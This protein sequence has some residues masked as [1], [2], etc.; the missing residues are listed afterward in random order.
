MCE[1][2]RGRERKCVCVC[3]CVI[4]KFIYNS[5]VV[6]QLLVLMYVIS[7]MRL[8][9]YR[10]TDNILVCIFYNVYFH[11][12]SLPPPSLPPLYLPFLSLPP[13]LFPALP[14]PSPSPLSLF[15]EWSDFF[16]EVD[17]DVVTG[18]NIVN[19]DLPYLL[20]RASTKKVTSSPIK[21]MS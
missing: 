16:Q 11:A 10:C 1:R 19:F 12:P 5:I 9:Y 6:L 7:R 15:Q 21:M 13:S 14:P 3:V 18:Y 17:P 2:E 4:L 8:N 20:N